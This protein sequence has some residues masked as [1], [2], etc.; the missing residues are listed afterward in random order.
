MCQETERTSTGRSHGLQ[1]ITELSEVE[2][3]R[4]YQQLAVAEGFVKVLVHGR[5]GAGIIS[6]MAAKLLAV[7]EPKLEKG[8]LPMVTQQAAAETRDICHVLQMLAGERDV[9]VST[10]DGVMQAKSGYKHLVR[11]TLVQQEYWRL[12]EKKTRQY[13][14]ATT[15]LTPE[16]ED[17]LAKLTGMPLQDVAQQLCRRLPVWHEGL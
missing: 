14:V 7:L 3:S 1:D 4:L 8:K 11:L 10:L 16:V 15:T 17:V 6:L 5:A 12:A 13:A 2:T 9:N